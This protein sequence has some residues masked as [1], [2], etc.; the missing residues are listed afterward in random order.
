MKNT[1]SLIM[2][3]VFFGAIVYF[4]TY[5]AF[6]S[7]VEPDKGPIEYFIMCVYT[8]FIYKFITSFR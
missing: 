4:S 3:L 7:A 5:A 6:L 2:N 1:F 8:T